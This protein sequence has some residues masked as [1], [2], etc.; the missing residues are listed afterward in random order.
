VKLSLSTIARA[1]CAAVVCLL[2][3]QQALA[4]DFLFMVPVQI[5]NPD[6]SWERAS[7]TCVVTGTGQNTRVASGTIYIDL[8]EQQNIKANYYV[9]AN[10]LPG[11]SLAD[12][13]EWSCHIRIKPKGSPGYPPM[14]RTE[15]DTGRSRSIVTGRF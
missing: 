5:S 14:S 9:P 15:H 3:S 8:P 11:A 4:A 10:L 7:V 13:K 2:V 12:A 1:A 6:P